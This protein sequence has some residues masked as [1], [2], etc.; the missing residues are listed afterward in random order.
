M[1]HPLQFS[2]AGHTRTA[3]IIMIDPFICDQQ[4]E[5]YI[6]TEDDWHSIYD[7][8]QDLESFSLE[9]AFGPND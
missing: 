3:L 6:P 5:E 2:Q 7:D 8:D 1:P 4:I 9:C